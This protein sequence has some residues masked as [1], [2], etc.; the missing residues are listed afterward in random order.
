MNNILEQISGSTSSHAVNYSDEVAQQLKT[1]LNDMTQKTSD[2]SGAMLS[3]VDG[4]A[5]A[6]KLPQ[7]FDK[8]RFAAMSSAFLA[9]SDNLSAEAGT[10]NTENAIIEGLAGKIFILHAGQNLL[11]TVFIRADANFG[12]TLAYAKQAIEDIMSIHGI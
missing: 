2:F 7:G 4:I 5:W 11:L 12:M 8:H 1:I 6:E 9:L 3:S 10:G